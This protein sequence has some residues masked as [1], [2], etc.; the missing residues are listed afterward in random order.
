MDLIAIPIQNLDR[1]FSTANDA[2]LAINGL[3]SQDSVTLTTDPA[4]TD[5]EI[6]ACQAFIDTFDWSA[7]AQA[8]WEAQKQQADAVARVL[9]NPDYKLLIDYLHDQIK[10]AVPDY[11]VPDLTAVQSAL[12]AQVSLSQDAQALPADITISP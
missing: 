6:K 12:T 11:V 3:Y 8:A 2:G 10:T 4:A 5:D 9:A 7:E 1:F